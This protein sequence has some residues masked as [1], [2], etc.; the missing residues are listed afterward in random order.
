[1]KGTMEILRADGTRETRTYACPIPV[2]DMQEAVDG[3][4]EP[5][6]RNGMDWW[7]EGGVVGNPRHRFVAFC[8]EEGLL[9]SMPL[10]KQASEIFRS[11]LV[12]PVIVIYG[13]KEFMDSL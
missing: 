10:N 11:A 2:E 3:Y 13:D 8:N 7:H 1:M 6:R 9:R 4:I 5:V 12:G